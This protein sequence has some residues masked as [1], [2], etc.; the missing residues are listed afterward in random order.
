MTFPF[1]ILY[2]IYLILIGIFLL[3]SAFN[4]YHLIRF[5]RITFFNLLVMAAYILI[6]AILLI[7]SFSNIN[8]IDWSGQIDLSPNNATGVFL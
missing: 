6:A 7:V 4:L 1:S 8:T 5:A 2:L 3:F